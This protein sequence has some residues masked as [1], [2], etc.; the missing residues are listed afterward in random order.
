MAEKSLAEALLAVQREAPTLTKDAKNPHFKNTYVTLES[1]M[2]TVLP[3]LNAH[4]IVLIQT[5]TVTISGGFGLRTRLMHV[6][7][8]EEVNDVMP[9]E[10]QKADPQGQGSAITYARRYSLM[11]ALGL[12]ADEDDDGNSAARPTAAALKRKAYELG[13]KLTGEEQPTQAKV[14][15][16]LGIKTG[17]LTDPAVLERVLKEHNAL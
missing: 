8:E 10:L 16:A 13:K 14:A 5:P 7:S 3:I 1:L 6:P 11:A 2:E 12:V 9:L 15:K 17:E 4:D